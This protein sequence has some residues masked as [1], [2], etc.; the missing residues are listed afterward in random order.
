MSA[1]SAQQVEYLGFKTL[2]KH[3]V[4]VRE[5]PVAAV[6]LRGKVHALLA[7]LDVKEHEIRVQAEA[8]LRAHS[9][10]VTKYNNLQRKAPTA[11]KRTHAEMEA[12]G[13]STVAPALP[14]A[15]L[16]QADERTEKM[17]KLEAD[18]DFLQREVSNLLAANTPEDA[19]PCR[20]SVHMRQENAALKALLREY[21]RERDSWRGRYMAVVTR[22]ETVPAPRESV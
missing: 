7:E 13:S 9:I 16:I 8:V 12:G 1:L 17:A 3:D 19:S 6:T 5:H 21:Q 20:C 15:A 2:W 18:N 11:R 14:P 10:D 4:F 22:I